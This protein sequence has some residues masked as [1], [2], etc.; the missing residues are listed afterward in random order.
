MLSPLSHMSKRVLCSELPR[1]ARSVHLDETEA[2]HV[3]SVLRLRDGDI[4]QAL[5]GKGNSAWVRL[6]TRGGPTRIEALSE[7]ETPLGAL[8][9][10][11]GT[12]PL[13]L[14]MAVLKGEAME[15]VIEKAV[16]LGVKKVIPVLTLRT[17]VRMDRKG[18]EEF[19]VRWEKIAQQ[20]L[21]QCGRLDQLEV[22]MPMKLE[23]LLADSSH[24]GSHG[25]RLWC[26][27]ETR[28]SATHSTNTKDDRI[29]L[30][31]WL[32]EKITFERK[33]DLR[34]LIGPEGG[35]DPRERDLLRSSE[36]TVRTQLG[37]LVLRAETAALY[38]ISLA[39]SF[40]RKTTEK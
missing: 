9:R 34:I 23:D 26:D 40:L 29:E 36:N 13:I 33:D 5:D 31:D 37:P 25:V 14:E 32:S 2:H 4:L 22:S 15:W 28:E 8:P 27:E 35:W 38:S 24:T 10:S 17:V 6:R 20:A 1:N 12:I 39:S 18:P 3:T 21:K 16:E 19:Q 7:T 30:L 11:H